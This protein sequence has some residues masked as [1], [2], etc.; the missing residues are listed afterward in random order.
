MQEAAPDIAEK[1]SAL[2][3]LSKHLGL[4]GKR[5]FIQPHE[6]VSPDLAFEM[7]LGAAVGL[8]AP[9]REWWQRSACAAILDILSP[10]W[11]ED[12]SPDILGRIVGRDSQEVRRWRET[13][14]ARDRYTCRHCGSSERLHAHH[15]LRWAD[16]PEARVAVENGVTLCEACHIA[17]HHGSR[18]ASQTDTSSGGQTGC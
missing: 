17:E 4:L 11:R 15:I 3:G 6:V 5:R 14:L 12:A 16:V 1:L 13:V 2:R 8:T 7:A 18:D 9:N 10:Q